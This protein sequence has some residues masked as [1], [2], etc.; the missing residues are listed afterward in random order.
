MSVNPYL[1][2]TGTDKYRNTISSVNDAVDMLNQFEQ[3]DVIVTQGIDSIVPGAHITVDN[4]DPHNP[5]VSANDAGG[6][7]ES[8]VAGTGISVDNTDPVNPIINNTNTAVVESVVA[9]TNITVDNTDPANPVVSVS[10]SATVTITSEAPGETILSDTVGPD[11]RTKAI[12]EGAGIDLTGAATSLT[13]S[14]L[15]YCR[16]SVWSLSKSGAFTPATFTVE[17]VWHVMGFNGFVSASDNPIGAALAPVSNPFTALNN[18]GGTEYFATTETGYFHITLDFLFTS[19]TVDD[20][21][22]AWGMWSTIDEGVNWVAKVPTFRQIYVPLVE[23][24]C[25]S[26]SYV[27]QLTD[28]EKWCFT[29]TV[30]NLAGA[31]FGPTTWYGGTVLTPGL[32]SMGDVFIA[33]VTYI[34]IKNT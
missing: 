13:V 4:T 24:R 27:V 23:E 11:F 15:S 31:Q 32:F 19:T 16:P 30:N 8:V 6:L 5:I 29:F 12:V 26:C 28:A 21:F 9:G 20:K 14:N 2:G 3:R 22:L 33:C 1:T 7:V 25:Y 34:K 18:A 10:S 17:D